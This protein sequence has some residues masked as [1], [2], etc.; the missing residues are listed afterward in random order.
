MADFNVTILRLFRP[1]NVLEQ[2]T[3]QRTKVA[4][5]HL[6]PAERSYFFRAT[7]LLT[8]NIP[9]LDKIQ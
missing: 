4:L 5:W 8:P 7:E 3:G 1:L 2:D 9:Q 6:R